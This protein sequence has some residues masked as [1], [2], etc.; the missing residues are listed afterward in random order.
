[1]KNFNGIGVV[2]LLVG[3][4]ACHTAPVRLDNI[5][6]MWKP[7]S[8]IKL[9]PETLKNIIDTKVQFSAFKDVRK[10][11]ELIAENREN[12]TPKP[13]TTRDNIGEFVS[14]HVRWAFD[15]AGLA[16]VDNGGDVVISGEVRQFFVDE[17]TTYKGRVQLRIIVL[18][19]AGKTLWTGATTGAASR[20][21]HSYSAENY[22]E[23]FSDSILD[24]VTS[25]IQD[26]DFRAALARKK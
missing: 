1:M 2:M 7:T 11:P 12:A 25:L 26:D 4:T 17:T 15:R 19:R 21:G 16:T 20:F 8:D 22:Y 23:V 5:P 10:N 18:D 13:V 24:A 6:L 14:A 3:F 9:P